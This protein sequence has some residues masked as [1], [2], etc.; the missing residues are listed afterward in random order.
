MAVAIEKINF[1]DKGQTLLVAIH[2]GLA[3]LLWILGG[4]VYHGDNMWQRLVPPY[5]I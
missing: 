4:T 1:F 2:D 5:D 3:L